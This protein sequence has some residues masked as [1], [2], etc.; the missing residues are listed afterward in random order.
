MNDDVATSSTAM[1][2]WFMGALAFWAITV[3]MM[4]ISEMRTERRHREALIMRRSRNRRPG[5]H[6]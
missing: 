2:A 3:A 6:S 1:L 5:P 4:W